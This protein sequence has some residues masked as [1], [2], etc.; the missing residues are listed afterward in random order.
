LNGPVPI[1]FSQARL[2]CR[3]SLGP[4]ARFTSIIRYGPRDRTHCSV[5][6]FL[7]SPCVPSGRRHAWTPR[8]YFAVPKSLTQSLIVGS[9][10]FEEAGAHRAIP[11]PTPPKCVTGYLAVSAR[12][13]KRSRTASPLGAVAP[14]QSA[15]PSPQNFR[16]RNHGAVF[17]AACD[18]IERRTIQISCSSIQRV[19]PAG[20]PVKTRCGA[21]WGAQTG[22]AARTF[23]YLTVKKSPLPGGIRGLGKRPRH[24]RLPARANLWH[25]CQAPPR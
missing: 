10:A 2:H 18:Q 21:R 24:R 5:C 7:E 12:A 22:A 4:S 19:R 17:R 20:P 8:Y 13:G 16:P 9:V 11:A 15:S 23:P 25:R 1:G 6:D 14:V 3:A